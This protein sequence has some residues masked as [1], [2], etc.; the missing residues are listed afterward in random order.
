M[1]HFRR[2]HRTLTIACIAA[3]LACPG[4]AAGKADRKAPAAPAPSIRTGLENLEK[5]VQ[6]FTLPNG[7]RFIVVER[8]ESPVFSFM[9]VVDAGSANDE[10]GTTGLAHMMEHM[11]FKGT[12]IVGTKDFEKEKQ[13][14]AAEEAAWNALLEERRRGARADTAKLRRLEGAFQAAQET[15]RELVV[16]NEFSK[17]MEQSGAQNANAFTA[18]DIT[19]YYYS[20]P[21]NQLEKWALMEG[22]R[23]TYPVFREF[24]K[25]REVVYEERRMRV[26]S[27]PMGRLFDEFIRTMFSAHPYGFGGIGYPSDLKTFSRAEGEQY[28]RTHYVAK[29]MTV[30]IVG[31]VT[32]AEVRKHAEKYFGELSDAPKPPPIDT[33][34]PEQ[35][36]ERRVLLEDP[37]QPYV[38]IGWH[39]PA[40]SDPSF[41]AYRALADLLAGGDHARLNKR[42]VKEKKIVTRIG[43][44]AGLIGEKYPTMFAVL[45]L[46]ASGQDPLAVEREI[47]ATIGEIQSAKPFTE[48][49]LD[50]YKVRVKAQKIQQAD[51]NSSLASA[52]AQAQVLYGDWREFFR[53]QERVQSLRVQDVM[54]VMQKSL[55]KKNRTVGLIVPPE[56]TASAGGSQ[57]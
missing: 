6:E 9:T 18:A 42:L 52:L 22:S 16:S 45:A 33:L 41:P 34:E 17:I 40:A 19:A 3:A 49:E 11:A 51:G 10:V 24:Y 27:S 48:E 53:E 4:L 26:E 37:A 8:H 15:A 20:I 32:V 5:Q 12:P 38:V 56:K 44:G 28:F 55:V 30:A 21:S 29:N 7:L 36:A 14:L 46:P 47:H 50:G 35:N 25:E 54:N 31:D 1:S 39:I 57:P 13:L 23:M 2:P 43:G